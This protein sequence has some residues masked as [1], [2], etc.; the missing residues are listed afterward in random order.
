LLNKLPLNWEPEFWTLDNFGPA[1]APYRISNRQ[2]FM[3]YLEERGY[4]LRDAWQVTEFKCDIAFHPANH[5][6]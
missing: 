5:L 3:S 4:V 1:V 6:R 2:A